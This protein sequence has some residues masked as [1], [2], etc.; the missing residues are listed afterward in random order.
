MGVCIKT[1]MVIDNFIENYTF[2]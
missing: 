2:Q 1:L